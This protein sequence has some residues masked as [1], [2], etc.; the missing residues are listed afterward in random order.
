MLANS[1]LIS[2]SSAFIYSDPSTTPLWSYSTGNQYPSAVAISSDGHYITATSQNN[3]Y[4]IN[5][6]ENGKLFLFDNLTSNAKKPLWNY[7]IVNSFCSVAISASGSNIVV[8]GGYSEATA[9]SFTN[10]NSTPHWLY[11]TGGWIYDVGITDDGT[12]AAAASGTR[13]K[14][15]LFNNTELSS[16]LEFPTTGLALRVALSSNGKYMA[17]TDNAAKLFF[18][19]TSKISPEWDY[20]LSGDMSVSLS[21]S[22]DG[23]YIASGGDKVYLFSK[24]SSVPIWTYNTSDEVGSIKVSKDG[25]YIAVGGGFADHN[26]YLFNRSN[27]T[28]EWIYL[29]KDEIASVAISYNGDY[30]AAQSYDNFLY[31]F[32]RNS[33]IPIWRYRLDGAFAS[34]YD[35][36]LDIS[37]DGRYIVAGG[38]HRI[39]LFDRDILTDPR[40]IIPGYNL[41][42]MILLIGIISVINVSTA[43]LYIKKSPKK[44]LL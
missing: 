37:S 34:S 28:P 26:V 2:E 23:N 35:Y 44:P 19:N 17:V 11:Y 25:N 36:N 20:T 10:A 29:T 1:L 18:F 30:I 39:Y 6:P 4:N 33:S 14:V 3:M 32:N 15:F 5:L 27:P 38:R 7:S 43:F 21:I 22:A 40:L 24:N 31:L 16:I 12:L 8:G 41:F 42:I 13:N 9:Y